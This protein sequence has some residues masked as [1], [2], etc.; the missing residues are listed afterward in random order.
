MVI[1]DTK[2]QLKMKYTIEEFIKDI[3]TY[4]NGFAVGWLFFGTKMEVL[5]II[6][7]VIAAI[8]Y[9]KVSKRNEKVS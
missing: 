5:D 7:F 2:K 6:M 9:L 8:T 3:P 4:L 1:L